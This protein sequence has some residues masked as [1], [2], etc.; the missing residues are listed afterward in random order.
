MFH[1]P[2]FLSTLPIMGYGMG[3]IF[4]VI[5]VIYLSIKLLCKFFPERGE[6]K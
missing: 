5:L 6:E 1:I 3:G 4:A 2:E